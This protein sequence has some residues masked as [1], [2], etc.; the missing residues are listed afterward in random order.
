MKTKI[1]ALTLAAMALINSACEKHRWDE[2]KKLFKEGEHGEAKGGH[3]GGES[4]G[5][6]KPGEEKKH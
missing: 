2:T 6:A 1:A 3:E 5:E 4:R